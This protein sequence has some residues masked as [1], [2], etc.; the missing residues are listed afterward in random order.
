MQ[1]GGVEDA[2]DYDSTVAI[3]SNGTQ[4]D[5]MDELVRTQLVKHIASYDDLR[6]PQRNLSRNS[7]TTEVSSTAVQSE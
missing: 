3:L 5:L 1:E 2:A 4:V 6:H 7:R